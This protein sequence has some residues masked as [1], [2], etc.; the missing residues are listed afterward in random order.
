MT[1]DYTADFD[2]AL[3]LFWQNVCREQAAI[4]FNNRGAVERHARADRE[5]IKPSVR[6]FWDDKLD[7]YDREIARLVKLGGAS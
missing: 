5:W 6:G 4:L 7:E 2:A 3:T 1:T